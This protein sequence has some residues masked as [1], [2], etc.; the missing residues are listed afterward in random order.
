[1]ATYEWIGP[2]HPLHAPKFYC[3]IEDWNRQ[4]GAEGH[5]NCRSANFQ[6]AKI[7]DCHGKNHVAQVESFTKVE[8]GEDKFGCNKVRQEK[9]NL[10][11][12]TEIFMATGGAI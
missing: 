10:N 11:C 12:K 1:M 3:F 7:S 4:Q 5:L 6:D 2:Q 8:G 9:C